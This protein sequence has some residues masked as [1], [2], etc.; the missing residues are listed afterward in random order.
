MSPVV[1]APE[2][3][4]VA[5]RL[6]APRSLRA[7]HR[8]E[9]DKLRLPSLFKGAILGRNH[10]GSGECRLNCSRQPRF[11]LEPFSLPLRGTYR[12][13]CDGSKE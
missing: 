9:L 10:G 7:A 3:G 8:A 1:E 6:P 4:V 12:R 2:R 11:P 5:E 13:S